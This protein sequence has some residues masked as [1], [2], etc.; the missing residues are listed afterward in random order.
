MANVWLAGRQ[1]TLS[2]ELRTSKRRVGM[3]KDA[4]NRVLG[5]WLAISP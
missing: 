2:V 1:S 4:T 3:R 5:L